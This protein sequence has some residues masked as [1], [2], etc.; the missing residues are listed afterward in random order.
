MKLAVDHISAQICICL[1]RYTDKIDL[2]DTR[3]EIFRLQFLA[4][5]KQL[6]DQ[7]L[8]KRLPITG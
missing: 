2:R 5:Q 8:K 7:N 4:L 1:Y 6:L 3:R